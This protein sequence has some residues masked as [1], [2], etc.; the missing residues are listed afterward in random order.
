MAA[1]REIVV[2]IP[3]GGHPA[4][5]GIARGS[6]IVGLPDPGS[7]EV[8]IYFEGAI[9]E[10]S[11]MITLADRAVH[12]CGRL[13]ERYPTV[14]TRMVP[15]ASLVVVG[16]FDE[17]SGRIMLT[18]EQSA[19]AV[20]AWLGVPILDPVELRRS[21]PSGMN[22]AELAAL[23]PDIQVAVTPSLATALIERGGLRREDD[24]WVATDGRRTSAIAEALLWALVLIAES[25]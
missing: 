14:A 22:P 7:E 19:A 4:T 3:A 20:A 12:A 25:D 1:S 23:V 13:R 2:Y 15:R 17:A 21:S 6:A 9:F 18:G 8:R 11:G 16:T 10:Q 24:R 5:G